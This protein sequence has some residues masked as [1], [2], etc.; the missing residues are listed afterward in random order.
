MDRFRFCMV[1][2]GLVGALTGVLGFSNLFSWSFPR[3]AV[4]EP[5][6]IRVLMLGDSLTSGLGVMPEQAWPALIQK[7]LDQAM[8]QQGRS[9]R[10]R[11]VNGGIS[12]STT[13]S[14][15]SRIKWYLK[16]PPRIMVLA[17]GA[18]DGLR[19]LAL[20][21]TREHLDK[22]IRTAKEAGIQVILAGMEIPPNMGPDYTGQFRQIFPELAADHD[23]PL[24]PFLLEGVAG[25][26]ELNQ[27]DGIHPN[28]RGHEIVAKTVFPFIT[29][30]L[31]AGT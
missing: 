9:D 11:V 28:A 1:I 29:E 10:V 30:A 18:N 2:V 8:A 13:A 4:A 24:I 27:A 7:M 5:A 3:L 22:A 16:S 19:G 23:I 31:H 15:V 25:H 26:P 17:L 14:A 6:Q 20:D 12:G 21:Q